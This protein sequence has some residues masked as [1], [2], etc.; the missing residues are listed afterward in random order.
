M[1]ISRQKN[2]VKVTVEDKGKGFEISENWL[3]PTEAGKFGLFNIKERMDWHGGA[4][5]IHSVPYNG[6]RA[7]LYVPLKEVAKSDEPI[8]NQQDSLLSSDPK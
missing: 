6:T 5:E 3:I 1:E 4:F 7:V 2:R 8:A